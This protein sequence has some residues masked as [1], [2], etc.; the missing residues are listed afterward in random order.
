MIVLHS[1]II[2]HNVIPGKAGAG[3]ASDASRARPWDLDRPLRICLL[4]YRTNPH[5]GGQ[6]VYI[7]NLSRALKDLGHHVEVV[8]GPPDIRLDPRIGLHR[9]ACLDLYNP[10]ALFRIPSLRELINPINLVEWLSVCTMGFPEPFTFGLRAFLFLRNRFQQYD[11]VHD[12]QSLSYGLLAVKRFIPTVATIHH[13]ITVDRNT[14]LRAAPNVMRKAQIMRWYSFVGMQKRVSKRLGHIITVSKS[15]R[16]DIAK[17]FGIPRDRFVVAP[18]GV[19]TSLFRP[20]DGVERDRNRVIVTNSSDI[21]LKGLH[22]LLKAVKRVHVIRPVNLV[23]I[24]TP[25]ENGRIRHLVSELGIGEIVKFTGRVSNEELVSHYA[26]AWVA[27]VPS[28]YEGFGLPA[29][30]AMACGV[31]VI[32]TTGGAL[33]EVVG[34]AGMLV[35][36]GD[37]D[38]LAYA[39]L[40]VLRNQEKAR[41]LGVKGYRRVLK[42]FTW[43]QA[44]RKTLQAYRETMRDHHRPQQTQN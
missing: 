12:N 26:R 39:L 37:S 6:G 32:S 43:E 41:T 28:L 23:V 38:A 24:G 27:V 1:N 25:K 42:N 33:P 11:I 22:Y 29:A 7:R 2:Q 20:V 14:A 3:M 40:E 10:E 16:D 44:A 9:L 13:P 5:C 34:D 17:E 30:E 18:N 19:D 15:A 35:P 4:S 8:T 36:P 21:P 31:P